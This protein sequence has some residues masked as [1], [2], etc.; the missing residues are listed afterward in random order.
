MSS[1]E[2]NEEQLGDLKEIGKKLFEN[3]GDPTSYT[4]KRLL[5]RPH[6]NF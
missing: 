2:F 6:I 4:Y 5:V 1:I 3:E